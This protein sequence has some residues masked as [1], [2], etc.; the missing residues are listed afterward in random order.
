M[1]IIRVS[2]MRDLNYKVIKF[3]EPVTQDHT[4]RGDYYDL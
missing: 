1:K 4:I 2:P 3:I